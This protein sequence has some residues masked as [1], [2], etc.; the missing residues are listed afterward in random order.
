MFRSHSAV[1]FVQNSALHL[2]V[3]LAVL[4][5]GCASHQPPP[6]PA[7]AIQSDIPQM[8]GEWRM[9]D[10]TVDGMTLPGMMMTSF[11]RVCTGNEVVVTN[12]AQL[13]MKATIT[14]DQTKNPKTIDYD[15]SDGPTKGSRHLGIYELDGDTLKSCFGDPFS[16]RPPDFTSKAG[17]RRT[18][19]VWKRVTAQAS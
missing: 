17:D 4:A 8:Q 10:S 19:T 13:I 7:V 1:H 5:G 18:Y 9:I 14:V 6:Q 16:T 11:K 3:I 12:G 15:V 2:A